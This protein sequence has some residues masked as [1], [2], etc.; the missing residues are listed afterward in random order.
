VDFT[1]GYAEFALNIEQLFVRKVDT[2][3]VV[4]DIKGKNEIEVRRILSGLE[5]LE[6]AQLKFWPFWVSK[7]PSNEE[8]I[9]VEIQISTK[10][11]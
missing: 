11:D 2:G 4:S 10:L 5:E 6:K 3:S 9:T 1:A 8:D 7:V